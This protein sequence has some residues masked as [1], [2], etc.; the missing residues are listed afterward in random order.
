[1]ITVQLP[2]ELLQELVN[3]TGN[4]DAEAA[5]YAALSEYVQH[6]KQLRVLD[7]EG[8]FDADPTYN[9]KEQRRVP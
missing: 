1:M 3:V 7:F 5:V 6:Q 9:Y 8:Q 2:D 4:A